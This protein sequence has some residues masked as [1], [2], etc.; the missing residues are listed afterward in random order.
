MIVKN[1]LEIRN[2]GRATH[3]WTIDGHKGNSVIDQML[4][5]RPTT[6][7][8]IQANYQETGF[9]HEVMEWEVQEDRQ[10]EADHERIE[11]ANLAAPTQENVEDV[12]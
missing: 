3:H 10:E 2:E 1:G 8:S 11:W 7:W 6:K 4:A 9:N 12:E 5:N